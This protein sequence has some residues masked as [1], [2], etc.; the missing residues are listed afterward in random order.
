MKVIDGKN[1]TLGRLASYAAKQALLGEEIV[2]LN[3]EK[4]IITGSRSAIREDFMATRRRT[5]SNFRGPRIS[6]KPE[7]VVKRVIRNML[8]NFRWGRGKEALEKIKCYVGTPKE[9]ENAKKI[10]AGKEKT[11]KF[12]TVEE[13]LK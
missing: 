8:P 2:I 12:I 4:V 10:I 5:G 11:N 3:V 13:M 6:K 9:Y 7:E 1:A